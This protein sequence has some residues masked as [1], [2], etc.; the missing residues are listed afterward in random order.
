MSNTKQQ[1][2]LLENE[3]F[4]GF[5][6]QTLSG[7]TKNQSFL[8]RRKKQWRRRKGT[9]SW[10]SIPPLMTSLPLRETTVT[11]IL[12]DL[13]MRPTQRGQ[14]RRR[15]GRPSRITIRDDGSSAPFMP[16]DLDSI[17]GALAGFNERSL[18]RKR[19]T[20]IPPRRLRFTRTVGLK[21]PSPSTVHL[22]ACDRMR[23]SSI[24]R[25]INEGGMW[26]KV[27]EQLTKTIDCG[28]QTNC[29]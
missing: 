13:G 5:L 15:S 7:S 26:L 8:S 21:I 14:T 27:G 23:L 4:T 19:R 2:E 22:R 28:V 20:S 16:T 6:R 3:S 18:G 24:G 11:F 12:P 10:S 17:R 29:L 1:T 9:S 25:V